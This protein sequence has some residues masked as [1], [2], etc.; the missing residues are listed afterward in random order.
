MRE[1]YRI[2]LEH[3][4]VGNLLEAIEE[5]LAADEPCTKF[6]LADNKV[7]KAVKLWRQS[8]NDQD[9]INDDPYAWMEQIKA[10][11]KALTDIVS[12]IFEDVL[13]REGEANVGGVTPPA[14]NPVYEAALN[15]VAARTE[16]KGLVSGCTG[17]SWYVGGASFSSAFSQSEDMQEIWHQIDVALPEFVGDHSLPS[18]APNLMVSSSNLKT[19]DKLFA[20]LIEELILTRTKP[21]VFA[22][23][24]DCLEPGTLLIAI[25]DNTLLAMLDGI[26][27]SSN[28]VEALFRKISVLISEFQDEYPSSGIHASWLQAVLHRFKLKP[29]NRPLAWCRAVPV[30]E[31]DEEGQPSLD[32]NDLILS[33]PDPGL[34]GG[35]LACELLPVLVDSFEAISRDKYGDLRIPWSRK[36]AAHL[37]EVLGFVEREESYVAELGRKYWWSPLFLL[38]VEGNWF[39][40]GEEA[41]LDPIDCEGELNDRYAARVLRLVEG[42]NNEGWPKLAAALLAY[43]LLLH[44]LR[45]V[46]LFSLRD[47][48]Q[49]MQIVKNSG[50]LSVVQPALKVLDEKYRDQKINLWLKQWQ[51]N[52]TV[53]TNSDSALAGSDDAG[54]RAGQ[55]LSAENTYKQH[56]PAELFARLDAKVKEKFIDFELHW[57]ANSAKLGTEY[58]SGYGWMITQL[59]IP[60]ELQLKSS[61][62]GIWAGES[63]EAL[64][65]WLQKKG[66]RA[67]DDP[68]IACY[69]RVL[70]NVGQIPIQCRTQIESRV[71]DLGNLQRACKTIDRLRHERNRAAHTGGGDENIVLKYRSELLKGGLLRDFCQA[72]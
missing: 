6:S 21:L 11:Q 68:D 63:G 16:Q 44:V 54:I 10:P 36:A 39:E 33:L 29:I 25:S 53:K 48:S 43:H 56:V 38:N 55:R 12:R 34:K 67:S 42:V 61:F 58:L 65:A 18:R 52:E 8:W 32:F 57:R 3:P 23:W 24:R 37:S 46:P 7:Q 27:E 62:H 15:Y 72:L 47:W 70:I 22:M 50:Q 28:A 60:F 66:L 59:F 13:E 9:S 26:D 2:F 19:Y 31:P 49:C 20:F 17:L 1:K 35:D 14:H 5:S 69:L 51:L 64:K 4:N 71:N 40:V 45:C 30:T 41:G